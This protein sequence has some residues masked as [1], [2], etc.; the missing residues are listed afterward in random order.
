MIIYDACQYVNIIIFVLNISNNKEDN[1]ANLSKIE[2]AR[3]K[4]NLIN[5]F[6]RSSIKI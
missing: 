5:K 3:K 2:I 4:L 6:M 1:L